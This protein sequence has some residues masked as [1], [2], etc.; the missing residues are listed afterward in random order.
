MRRN[1]RAARVY[2]LLFGRVA[3][4][5]RGGQLLEGWLLLPFRHDLALP[6]RYRVRPSRSPQRIFDK[7]EGD[8]RCRLSH[9]PRTYAGVHATGGA[10]RNGR[11]GVD[12]LRLLQANRKS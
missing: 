3:R 12:R 7:R 5:E 10:Q 8:S 4:N 2:T 6:G 9:R 1:H 11:P